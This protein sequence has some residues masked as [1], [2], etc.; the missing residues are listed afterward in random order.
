MSDLLLDA[1]KEVILFARQMDLALAK[2]DHDRGTHGWQRA[3]SYLYDRLLD[4]LA[5]LRNALMDDSKN[6][7]PSRILKEAADVANYCM[8]IADNAGAFQ[9]FGDREIKP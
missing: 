3:Q 4:E 9:Y 6:Q 8:M 2:H 5:E 1:R 7:D